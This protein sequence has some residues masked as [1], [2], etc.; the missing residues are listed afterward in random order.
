MLAIIKSLTPPIP[1]RS[2]ARLLQQKI[3]DRLTRDPDFGA[4]YSARRARQACRIRGDK[5][6]HQ[7]SVFQ[8]RIACETQGVCVC[9]GFEGQINLDQR[10]ESYV[11]RFP[12]PGL[13]FLFPM[14]VPPPQQ[15]GAV[16]LTVMQDGTNTGGSGRTPSLARSPPWL[17]RPRNVHHSRSQQPEKGPRKSVKGGARVCTPPAARQ[18]RPL[19]QKRRRCPRTRDRRR[20]FFLL[21]PWN[22]PSGEKPGQHP[23]VCVPGVFFSSLLFGITENL[24]YAS[25]F[26]RFESPPPPGLVYQ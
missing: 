6:R 9:P 22:F 14:T 12:F 15:G 23:R 3:Y 20:G 19:P 2:A 11:P 26:R 10:I 8:I 24:S 5:G 7:V 4:S 17:S 1:C 16:I 25:G 13:S 18:G 21:P